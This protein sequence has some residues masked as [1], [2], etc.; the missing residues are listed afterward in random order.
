MKRIFLL[1]TLLLALTSRAFCGLVEDGNAKLAI[2]DYDGAIANYTEYIASNPTTESKAV[3][4]SDRSAAKQGKGDLDGAIA[5]HTKAIELNPDY[6]N[7]YNNRGNAKKDKG[8]LGGAIADYTKAIELEPDGVGAYY[9]N[10]GNANTDKGDFASAIADYTKAIELN[11]KLA[12]AYH[13]RGCLRYD[14]HSFTDA[15]GDFRKAGELDMATALADYARISVW[16]VRARLGE[17]AAATK[18][19]QAY[20]ENRK[21]GKP[22]DWPS[23][24]ARYLTGQLAEPDF[25][26]AAANPD[27]KVESGQQCEAYFY[28]GTKRLITGDKTTAQDY[29]EKCLATGGKDFT[30]YSSAAAELK[31]LRAAK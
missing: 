9:Y 12:W 16:R 8:D 17:P 3:A 19:L 25:F 18:E 28:A 21:T 14:Q 1:L 11:P 29:F 4:Y 7:A 27:K 10:R 31:F 26:K 6:A 20:L 2:G 13:S 5:D 24:I 23:S 30:E 15:L 22:G